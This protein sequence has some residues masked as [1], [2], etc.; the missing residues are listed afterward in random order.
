MKTSLLSVCCGAAVAA[1]LVFASVA[2][3]SEPAKPTKDL[4]KDTMNKA[5]DAAK[6]AM[7]KTQDAVKDAAKEA[8][9]GA[10][11]MMPPSAV[12][13][14]EV[15]EHHK[16]LESWVGEWNIAS[17]WYAAEGVP[18]VENTM[19]ATTKSMMGGRYFVEKVTGKLSFGE[20]SPAMDFEGMS[21]FG[22]DNHKKMHWSTWMDNMATGMWMETGSCSEDGKVI[23]TEGENYNSMVGQMQKTKSISTVIDADNRKLEMWGPGE[24]GKMM[25][26]MEMTYT[27]K[28]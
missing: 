5:K 16:R 28:K 27:R 23:T 15:T 6:D 20:G 21:V 14:M 7:K 18:P 4:A 9:P 10:D 3:S 8:M 1:S 11:E 13:Y 12:E 25:K 22:Y 2:L 19:T 26:V 17:K 24:D